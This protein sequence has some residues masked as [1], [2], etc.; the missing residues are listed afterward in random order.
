MAG[1]SLAPIHVTPARCLLAFGRNG[2]AIDVH[3]CLRALVQGGFRLSS[4]LAGSCS[5]KDHVSATH[6]IVWVLQSQTI[7]SWLLV[8]PR[9]GWQEAALAPAVAVCFWDS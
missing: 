4:Y 6:M 7:P 5:A 3:W 9:C 1:D 8:K 2:K